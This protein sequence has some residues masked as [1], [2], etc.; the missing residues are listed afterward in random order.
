[1]VAPPRSVADAGE[2]WRQQIARSE[3]RPVRHPRFVSHHVG[4]DGTSALH[5]LEGQV[6]VRGDWMIDEHRLM[7]GDALLPATGYVEL[8]RAAL[9]ETGL[10]PADYAIHA[11]TLLRPFYVPEDRPA[12]F[13]LRLMGGPRRWRVEAFLVSADDSTRLDLLANAR[14]APVG[15][16]AQE[17]ANLDQ[18]RARCTE[19]VETAGSG[20]LQT[21]QEAHLRFGSRWRVLRRIGFGDREALARLELDP[22]LHGDLVQFDSHPALLDVATGC[23]MDLIPG[24]REQETPLNLWV[25]QGYGRYVQHRPLPAALKSWIRLRT[26]SSVAAGKV[27]FDIL[28]F[29][30]QGQLVAELEE[31]QLH[32][33]QGELPRE[34]VTPEPTAA[35]PQSPAEKALA[36]NLQRGF[37]REDGEWAFRRLLSSMGLPVQVASTFQP[38]VLL[39]QG[40]AVA[41]MYRRTE[42]ARFARPEL[43][44]NYEAPRDELEKSLAD[45]WG[46]LLGVEGVGIRDSFFDLGGHSLVAVRLF[47]EIAERH[48]I[49]LPLSVL[50]QHPDVASLAEKI[51]G[52]PPGQ[53][54]VELSP[55][56]ADET[57]KEP[58]FTYVVPMHASTVGAG[59]PLFMVAGMFG[60][61]LNLSHMAHL[62][63]E[64]RPFYA[65]QARGLFADQTPFETF[66]E[67]ATAYL[68]EV[69]RLQPQGPYLLGGFSGGGLIAFEMARQL[70]AAGE[71][72]ATILMLD[73]PIRENDQL[74]YFNKL[75]LLR[76]GL[77]E[78]GLSHL[79]RKLRD[80]KAWKESLVKREFERS[81]EREGGASDQ[82]KFRSQRVGDA[83]VRALHAYVIKP[84]EVSVALFRPGCVSNTRCATAAR[85]Q[86]IARS[87]CRTT[88]GR[89]MS[90]N[91]R[92][93]RCRA[94]TT[95][96]SWSPMCACWYRA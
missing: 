12:T 71:K 65:L 34:V 96:W 17:P 79:G 7:R 14:I 48:G 63:G 31:L 86:P 43:D 47:N 66:E 5:W 29:D 26:G 85:L 52:G 21:R 80:R 46:R 18:I 3:A 15:V 64:D 90:R 38:D 61:V 45:L 49:D 68:E 54:P 39:K 55:A 41:H 32:K 58:E 22:A 69:R 59:A 30:D 2:T 10:V 74:S 44:S 11:L 95:A 56:N 73:T 24:Y 87:C 37:T 88:D 27:Q 23:A 19:H 89:L 91:S 28:L 83:F 57:L 20:G 62:L 60:N 50:M 25:P 33:L 70:L 4:S 72:V 9:A 36:H 76:F 75:E 78:E 67:M 81:Q 51:R 13:R 93:R 92:W 53:A 94:T 16:V 84:T 1:M 82:H 35:K 42:S 77:E 40:E 6:S 8:I